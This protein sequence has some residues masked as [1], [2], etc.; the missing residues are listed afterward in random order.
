MNFEV[1]RIFEHNIEQ[2]MNLFTSAGFSIN[3]TNE[4]FFNNN[5]NI[6]IVATSD[7]TPYGFLYA[8]LLES[9]DSA[10]N[11]MFLYSIDVFS[12]F[13]QKGVGVALIEE[14]KQI[15]INKHCSEIFVFT[16]D[17]NYGAKKLYEKTGGLRENPDD[18]M[19]VYPL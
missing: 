9:I 11:K 8:Y 4:R 16:N 7:N 18:V 14:L 19:Y 6:L 17:S 2:I 5:N 15:A 1:K 10:R 3:E 12:E 13:Q